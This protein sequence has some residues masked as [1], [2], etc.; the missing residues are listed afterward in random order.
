MTK[1]ELLHC[2]SPAFQVK[3]NKAVRLKADDFETKS[4]DVETKV[5]KA[6]RKSNVFTFEPA[7][8]KQFVI[9][10]RIIARVLPNATPR[11]TVD[12]EETTVWPLKAKK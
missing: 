10:I 7:A 6:G 9:T 5:K 4:E 1:F 12:Q 3:K 11:F 2:W 8:E